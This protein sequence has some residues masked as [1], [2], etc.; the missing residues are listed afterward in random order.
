MESIEAF[1]KRSV[2]YTSLLVD[3]IPLWKSSLREFPNLDFFLILENQNEKYH[4]NL[5]LDSNV[6]SYEDVRLY[7]S[8]YKEGRNYHP[9]AEVINQ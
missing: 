5:M 6:Q 7:I 2:Y 1:E 8:G 4:W 9:C 3:M